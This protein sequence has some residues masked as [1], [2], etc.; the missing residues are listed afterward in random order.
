MDLVRPAPAAPTGGGTTATTLR[1]CARPGCADVATATLAFRYE[2]SQAWLTPLA[3]DR[4]PATYDLCGPCADRTSPPRGWELVDERPDLDAPHAA[5]GVRD[6]V[7]D[8][9]AAALRGGADAPSPT[10]APD[11]RAAQVDADRE[12]PMAP[13]LRAE[14]EVA[15]VAEVAESASARAPD[16]VL[17][18]DG[19]V[20]EPEAA[21]VASE[22]PGSGDTATDEPVQPRPAQTTVG[23][24]RAPREV[25]AVRRRRPVEVLISVPAAQEPGPS[26]SFAGPDRAAAP[27]PEPAARRS[28]EHAPR[29]LSLVVSAPAPAP[30]PTAVAEVA[31]PTTQSPPAASP[32]PAAVVATPLAFDALPD[33][34]VDLGGA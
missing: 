19:D 24:G 7:R 10:V 25:L 12:E 13:A 27:T 3:D 17:E 32:A 31:A 4:S 6:A 34:L 21:P 5:S 20:R 2:G 28:T 26:E 11:E 29:R 16:P 9:I 1:R 15:E 8:A 22:L 23:L 14:A 18:Q 30:K 33:R